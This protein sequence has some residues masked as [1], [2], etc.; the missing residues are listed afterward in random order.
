M[1]LLALTAVVNLHARSMQQE[2]PAEESG[3]RGAGCRRRRL[4]RPLGMAQVWP[5]TYQGLAVSS[6]IN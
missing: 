3:V 2:E 4:H 5:E 6:V 1:R